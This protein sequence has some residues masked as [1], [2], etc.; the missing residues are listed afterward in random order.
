M[1]AGDRAPDSPV[2][3]Q[4]GQPV[5]LFDLFRGPHWTL[6]AFDAE[7]PKTGPE[8]HVHRID[9]SAADAW[10]AYDV[11]GA[12]LVLV[13]PDGYIGRITQTAT[14]APLHW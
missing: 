8:V 5:R 6:L 9:A 11:A 3:D 12:T 7:P 4:D 1:R 10:Q 13:R 14:V 2:R